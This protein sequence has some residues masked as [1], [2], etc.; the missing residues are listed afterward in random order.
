MRSA[1]NLIALSVIL[2]VFSFVACD[3]DN[4]SDSDKVTEPDHN[5][6]FDDDSSTDDDDDNND[7][8]NDAD[9]IYPEPC[10]EGPEF[11]FDLQSTPMIVP[12]PN[13]LYTVTDPASN[14]GIRVAIDRNTAHPVGLITKKK[15]FSFITEAINRVDGFSTAANLYLPVGQ[16]PDQATYS[17]DGDPSFDDAVMVMVDDPQNKFDMEQAFLELAWRSPYLRLIPQKPLR[18]N[19]HYLLIATRNLKPVQGECYRASSDM[20]QIWLDWKLGSDETWNGQRY[21]EKFEKLHQMGINPLDVLSIAEFNTQKVTTG[22]EIARSRID[23]LVAS[24]SPSFSDWEVIPHG[25][26]SLFATAYATFGTPNFR[27]DQGKWK[28][29][30]QE[31]L[32]LDHW[33]PI[34]ARFTIPADDAHADGQPYPVLIFGHGLGSSKEEFREPF[35][36]FAAESGFAVAGIDFVCHGDRLTSVLGDFGNLL[37]FMN[38]FKPESFRDAWR[39][40]VTDTL[41]FVQAIKALEDMDLDSNGVPDFDVENIYFMGASLGSVLGGSITALEPSIGAHVLACSGSNFTSI[42][43]DGSAQIYFSV[44]EFIEELFDMD[45]SLIEHAHVLM[46][47]LQTVAEPADSINYITHTQ[48]DPFPLMDGHTPQ[49]FQQGSAWDD[50]LGGPSGGYLCRAGG[51]PQLEP[52]TWDVGTDH[53]SAPY[54]GSGFYQYDTDDHN[55]LFERDVWGVAVRTQ[56]FH[57]LRTH[58]ETGTGEIIDPFAE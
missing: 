7:N 1:K 28:F 8:D 26:P 37:C 17:Y 56:I 30:Y 39:Q 24:F 52:F 54:P 15:M 18:Q 20:Q 19:T 45:F 36:S 49:I 55:F 53:V 50:T 35:M 21:V 29:D 32:I 25:S 34:R 44:V 31:Q 11:S 9:I 40:S 58:L 6:H 23:E 2:A 16:A 10:E 48:L 38:F 47:L 3:Q 12:F 43:L 42:V 33:E 5:D 51:W 13:N 22:L 41:W 4:D 57:F 27:N 46:A 14:T